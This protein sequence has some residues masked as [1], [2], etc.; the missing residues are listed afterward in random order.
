MFM[1]PRLLTGDATVDQQHR[2]IYELLHELETSADTP[3]ELMRALEFMAEYILMHFE[4]E[5]S[6][7]RSSGYPEADA[8]A[9]MAEH[10]HLTDATRQR[11]CAFREGSL[12]HTGE[13]AEFLRGWL[14]GHVDI[15]DRALVEHLLTLDGSVDRHLAT[16][17]A[18]TTRRQLREQ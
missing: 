14:S 13:L 3:A 11:I 15:F 9:H 10:R 8:A 6:L 4:A 5:E 18:P 17:T 1:D 7:M 2:T 12:R 16:D